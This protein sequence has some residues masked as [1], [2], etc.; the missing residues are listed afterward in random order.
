KNV[1]LPCPLGHRPLGHAFLALGIG[2]ERVELLLVDLRRRRLLRILLRGGRR[3]EERQERE[4]Q[5]QAVHDGRS[6]SEVMFTQRQADAEGCSITDYPRGVRAGK[7]RSRSAP[8]ASVRRRG[9]R[10][11]AA[12]SGA[13]RGAAGPGD[14][15]RSP[16]RFP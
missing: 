11:G 4:T 13:L 16:P 14:T 6:P 2:A 9:A 12:G 5:G 10:G 1:A 8:A 15:R 3:G 7:D